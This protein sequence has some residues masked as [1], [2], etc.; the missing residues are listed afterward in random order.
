MC[1][2]RSTRRITINGKTVRVDACIAGL[3]RSLNDYGIETLGSCCGHG[4]YPLTIVYRF[5]KPGHTY[6]N[7][8][9]YDFCSGWG[10]IGRKKRFYVKDKEGYYFIPEVKENGEG[11]L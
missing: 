10:I 9:L 11:V 2:K 7:G 6:M 8:N 1:N 3:I 4:K 5:N